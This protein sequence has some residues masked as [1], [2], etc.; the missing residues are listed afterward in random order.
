MGSTLQQSP[1]GA[2]PPS[3]YGAMYDLRRPW[4][5]GV[6]PPPLPAVYGGQGPSW[7]RPGGS[8]CAQ[9]RAEPGRTYISRDPSICEAYRVTCPPGTIPLRDACGCGCETVLSTPAPVTPGPIPCPPGGT[10][11]ICTAEYRPTCGCRVA[12]ARDG[13]IRLD[14]RT[15]SNPC[16]ACASATGSRYRFEGPCPGRPF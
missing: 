9:R 12:R 5:F 1:V 3:P 11:P 2:P 8:Y 13:G 10:G 7:G 6:P 15:Y 14:C 4:S 16:Q